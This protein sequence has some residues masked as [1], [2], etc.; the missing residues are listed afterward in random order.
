MDQSLARW[1]SRDGSFPPLC[2]WYGGRDYLVC[3]DKLVKRIRENEE[4]VKVL[5]IQ[6]IE[7]AEVIIAAI[8][9]RRGF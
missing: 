9:L 5:R 3:V 2:L 6:K 8:F 4:G 1:W 7:D